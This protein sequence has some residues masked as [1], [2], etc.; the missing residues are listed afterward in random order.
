MPIP[1]EST[2]TTQ[3]VRLLASGQPFMKNDL[4]LAL[5]RENGLTEEERT[6]KNGRPNFPNMTDWA[7]AT[8]R[9]YGFIDGPSQGPLTLSDAG[10]KL[11]KQ[12]FAML[13]RRTLKTAAQTLSEHALQPSAFLLLRSNEASIW[14]D[15]DAKAYHFGRTVPNYTKIVAG[16]QFILDRRFSDGA[17]LIGFGIID[18]VEPESSEDDGKLVAT[19]AEYTAIDP[20]MAISPDQ[21]LLLQRLPGFNRQHSVRVLNEGVYERLLGDE[22]APVDDAPEPVEGERFAELL[23]RTHLTGVEIRDILDLLKTKQQVI[24]EGPPGAGKTYVGELI[25]RYFSNNPFEGPTDS[26]YSIVQF[27]QSY[28][29]E[30]FIQGIRP[31][32]SSQGTLTYHLAPGIFKRF[33]EA[34]AGQ[35]TPFVF[36][37]DEINR[38]NI[39]RI[40]GELLLLLEYREKEIELAYTESS[41]EG[42]ESARFKIPSNVF[43]IA[44][45][46]TTDRSLAQIDYA[47]RR[48]FYFYRLMPVV[49]G[50]APILSRWLESRTD[51]AESAKDRIL[52]AFVALNTRLEDTLGDDFQVGHSYFMF[53]E[54]GQSGQLEKV[55]QRAII[56]LVSEYLYGRRDRTEVLKEFALENL[57][58]SRGER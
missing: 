47:L 27:H 38:G 44:T 3:M 24:L 5:A 8:L 41:P 29:Y 55:W 2:L 23:S 30:D 46:N 45:M 54:I 34:A 50:A 35:T 12:G 17:K 56:P 6:Q 11:A 13:D 15:E 26:Q 39:S 52:A 9:R 33:C 20:P 37:I 16:A 14:R 51:I 22:G 49:A 31:S 25:G 57:L 18:S 43:I 19:Y 32:T 53:S 21:S 40:F 7:Q 1:S 42:N 10:F 48:R 4:R 36:L 58:S 28:G